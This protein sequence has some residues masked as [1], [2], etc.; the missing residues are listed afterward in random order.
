MT[1]FAHDVVKR[2]QKQ[3]GSGRCFRTGAADDDPVPDPN[4]RLNNFWP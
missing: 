3:C 4:V 1:T 2:D